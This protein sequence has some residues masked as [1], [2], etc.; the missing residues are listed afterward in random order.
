MT[1]LKMESDAG[2]EFGSWTVDGHPRSIQFPESFWREIL[3]AVMADFLRLPWGGPDVGGVLFGRREPDCVRILAFRRL[4]CEHD[5]GPAFELSENDELR[6]RDLLEKART[7]EELAGLEAVGWYHSK[8]DWLV[9]T[10]RDVRL[11]DRY[12]PEPWQIAMVFLRVRS[13]PSLLGL[14]FR[15]EDGSIASRHREFSVREAP[16]ESPSPPPPPEPEPAPE[17]PPEPAPQ[18]EEIAPPPVVP[19]WV[20]RHQAVLLALMRAIQGRKGLVLL[21]GEAGNGKTTLLGRLGDQLRQESIEFALLLDPRL[22]VEEFYE[23]LADDL[24]LPCSR[25]SKVAVLK[26]LR[27]LLV[28]QAG[29]GRHHGASRR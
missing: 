29:K 3:P 27:D 19:H 18:A 4:E 10:D 24:A 26:A 12:F 17:A 1:G 8:H 13:Q 6:L 23:F 25:R 22:S 28:E 14:F 9:L 16:P 5:F 20:F 7:E 11:Y 15:G 21:S 2:A